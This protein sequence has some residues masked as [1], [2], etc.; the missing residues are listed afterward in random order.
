[1]MRTGGTRAPLSHGLERA[2]ARAAARGGEGKRSGGGVTEV[3]CRNT[4]LR[5]S[6]APTKGPLHTP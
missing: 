3:S 4:H 2:R 1:M 6:A 5:L